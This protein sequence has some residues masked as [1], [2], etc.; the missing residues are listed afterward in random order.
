MDTILKLLR[1]IKKY[2]ILKTD[3]EIL[4]TDYMYYKSLEE[5]IIR[6]SE[7]IGRENKKK[8]LKECKEKD[9]KVPNF[10]YEGIRKL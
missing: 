8:I 1:Q 2:R 3:G 4:I 6:E 7:K 5:E 9:W 10:R